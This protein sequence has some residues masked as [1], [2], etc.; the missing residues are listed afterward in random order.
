MTPNL[1]DEICRYGSVAVAGLAKNAGK[2]EC[3]NYILRLARD[4]A[5][6]LAITSIGI[7]GESRDQVSDTRKP[8]II[9]TEGMLFTTSEK[10]YRQR[11][12]VAEIVDVSDER[13]SLGRL[14]TAR[15]L[16]PGKV[17]LS[18]PADTASLKRLIGE[19]H[20]RGAV[21]VI[22]DGAL[23][24]L[25]LSSP[26]VTEAMVLATGAALSPDIG[27]IV[28]QTV[29]V[30]D[31]TRLPLTTTPAAQELKRVERGLRTIDSHGRVYDPGIASAYLLDKHRDVLFAHGRT[32]FAP[33]AVTDKMLTFLSAQHDAEDTVLIIKDF[34]RMFAEPQTFYSF[35]R[36]GGKIEVLRRNRLLAV[37]VNPTSPQGYKVDSEELRR[38][39]QSKIDVP[40]IDVRQEIGTL[41]KPEK[42]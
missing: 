10:H 19:L 15:V 2:T 28:R 23:S 12:L 1:A 4:R 5:D 40:V 3:L 39:L 11:R 22:V 6:S 33:G 38:A 25:S 21:T 29:Y 30:Y 14:V 42:L 31:L 17:I 20:H 27:R 8:E 34:T 26:T 36:K 13:T 18:G 7:D 24:R 16:V 9:L 41:R 37:S 35:L 32:I